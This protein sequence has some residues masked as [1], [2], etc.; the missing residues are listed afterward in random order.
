MQNFPRKSGPIAQSVEQMAFNH[1]VEGSSPS[2]I[3]IFIEEKRRNF[4]A[5]PLTTYLIYYSIKITFCFGFYLRFYSGSN[6]SLSA[7][8]SNWSALAIPRLVF[9]SNSSQ[10]FISFSN[11]WT[12]LSCSAN[13]GSGIAYF[14]KDFPVKC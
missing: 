9:A 5:F 3:T 8:C 10:N 7:V 4:A 6:A 2:R 12:I 1:W 11:L 13:G 14:D